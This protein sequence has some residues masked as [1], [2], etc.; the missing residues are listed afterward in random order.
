MT[1]C[2]CSCGCRAGCS[3]WALI[4]A[5][6][7]GVLTAFF[8]I[9]GVAVLTTAFL[10]VALGVGAGYL[11]LLVLTGAGARRGERTG[12]CRILELLLA[13]L[14]GT[15]LL[16]LLLLAVGITAT[17]ILSALLAGGLVFFL[18]LV[19]GG[20]ACYIRCLADCGS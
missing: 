12:C 4:L 17:S 15:I 20:S 2:N 11:A 14:L 5:A 13:A 18:V 19:F 7:A 9:T 6:I 10:W 1:S 16:A 8:Q 3:L